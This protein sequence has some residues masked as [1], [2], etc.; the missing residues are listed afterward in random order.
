MCSSLFAWFGLILIKLGPDPPSL[1]SPNSKVHPFF[2]LLRLPLYLR[3]PLRGP[4]PPKK[5]GHKLP[6][7]HHHHLQLTWHK[8][9]VRLGVP[10]YQLEEALYSMPDDDN[11]KEYIYEDYDL[12]IHNDIVVLLLYGL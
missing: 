11:Y 5:V 3:L 12:I 10:D 4:T 1:V 7:L 8:E 6:D 2:V 9:R